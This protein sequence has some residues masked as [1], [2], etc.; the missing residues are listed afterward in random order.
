M[1]SSSSS[2]LSETSS[3]IFMPPSSFYSSYS[4]SALFTNSS[5]CKFSFVFWFFFFLI[6]SFTLFRS[7]MPMFLRVIFFSPVVVAV[8]SLSFSSSTIASTL[9]L[10]FCFRSCLNFTRPLSFFFYGASSPKSAALCSLSFSFSSFLSLFS[11]FFFSF[12]SLN[13]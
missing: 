9:F 4:S 7:P 3:I 10:I 11:S 1:K 2:S 5:Y 6:L 13:S 8:S 12:F